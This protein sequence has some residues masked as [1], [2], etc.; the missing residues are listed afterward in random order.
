LLGGHPPRY[1]AGEIPPVLPIP[2]LPQASRRER[3]RTELFL[4]G[5]V[6]YAVCFWVH[7]DDHWWHMLT[8]RL[9]LETGRVP[10]ADPF[11]FTFQG[12][13]WTNWEW[14][15]GVVMFLAWSAAGPLGLVLLRA[16]AFGGT[17]LVVLRHWRRLGGR[18]L[19][20]LER[21]RELAATL[22]GAALVLGVQVRV[23]DR[24]HT[25]A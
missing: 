8:G 18:P 4:V 24:P 1:A 19:G 10:A 7:C 16:L 25:Y 22:V 23:A 12:A 6:L 2:N 17:V 20:D 14:L 3:L 13:P 5:I 21:G 9:I 11:S 15:A